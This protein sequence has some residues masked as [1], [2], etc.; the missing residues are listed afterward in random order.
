MSPVTCP[1]LFLLTVVQGEKCQATLLGHMR[2]RKS[3]TSNVPEAFFPNLYALAPSLEIQAEEMVVGGRDSMW[4]L[5][6]CPRS[7][8]VG[9]LRT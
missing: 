1:G 6:G 5:K 2:L 7:D 9:T 8:E 3:N 4:I